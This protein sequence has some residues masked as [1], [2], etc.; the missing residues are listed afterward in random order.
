M[1]KKAII[2]MVALILVFAA[3]SD[4]DNI[5]GPSQTIHGSGDLVSE[6]RDLAAFNTIVINT[7]AHIDVT[8]GTGQEAIVTADDNVIE[9][10][11]TRVSDG[12]LYISVS[13]NVSIS[14]FTLELDLTVTDLAEVVVNSVASVVGHGSFDRDV[15]FFEMNSV[16]SIVFDIDVD[17]A[18][19]ANNSVG[20]IDLSGT[21]TRHYA[22]I[23]SVGP[24]EAFDLV[25]D[26]SIVATNSVGNAYV[27]ANDFLRATINS[28]GSIYYRGYPEIQLYDNSTGQLINAN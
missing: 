23:S 27:T 26:T 10:I 18:Y 21:A 12:A 28:T 2:T 22:A 8:L 15:M 24:I 7:V 13:D 16:G 19:S 4:N 3:C 17:E 11:S 1:F 6:T 25:T 20:T 9:F 5:N 14:D